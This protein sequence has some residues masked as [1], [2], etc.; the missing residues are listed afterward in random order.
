MRKLSEAKKFARIDSRVWIISNYAC[1]LGARITRYI[2][3]IGHELFEGRPHK[4]FFW[5]TIYDFEDVMPYLCVHRVSPICKG[6]PAECLV[7]IDV[8]CVIL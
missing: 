1:A 6:I 4:I 2:R 5:D 3:V 8:D 7:G